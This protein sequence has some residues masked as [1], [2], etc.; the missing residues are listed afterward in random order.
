[1][2]PAQIAAAAMAAGAVSGVA[3]AVTGRMMAGQPGLGKN[4]GP[5]D[6]QTERQQQEERRVKPVASIGSGMFF[7][8]AGLIVDV[9]SERLKHKHT[10]LIRSASRGA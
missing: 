7:L 2:T 3:Q 6:E 4:Q 8:S 9:I 10:K 1:M 5:A